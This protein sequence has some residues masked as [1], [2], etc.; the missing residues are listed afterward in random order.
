MSF[1]QCYAITTFLRK[2]GVIERD[3][4]LICLIELPCVI[5]KWINLDRELVI[6]FFRHAIFVV[7]NAMFKG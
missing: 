6:E 2:S 3:E 4:D 5:S 1:F 7:R